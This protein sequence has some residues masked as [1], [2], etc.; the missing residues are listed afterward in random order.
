[1]SRTAITA[2]ISQAGA[3]LPI[4]SRLGL[5]L[6]AGGIGA[7]VIAHVSAGLEHDHGSVT[8]GQ[9]SAHLI[10]FIGMALVLIG[11]VVDGVFL[12]RHRQAKVVERNRI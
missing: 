7:D 3:H 1:M 10:V 5:I 11:I 2:W 4:L 12:T 9:L 8:A 6:I